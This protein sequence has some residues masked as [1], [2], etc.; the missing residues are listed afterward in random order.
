MKQYET[1]DQ[2]IIIFFVFF[3]FQF[4]SILGLQNPRDIGSRC[5]K[6]PPDCADSCTVHPIQQGEVS[7]TEPPLP[8]PSVNGHFPEKWAYFEA[9]KHFI[10]SVGWVLLE[11][12]AEGIIECVTDNIVDLVR[13]TSDELHSQS[14]YSYLHPGD[15]S[16]LSPVL[17]NMSFALSWDQ[18][19]DDRQ[20]RKRQQKIRIRLLVKPPEGASETMEQKQQRQDKYEDA[21]LIAAP[22]N[23]N[24]DDTSSVLCLI[25]RPEDDTIDVAMPP[26]KLEQ[27]TF[28]VDRS[29]KITSRKKQNT[30]FFNQI[31][32]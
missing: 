16:K 26:Q 10:A 17:N 14:I 6:C 3:Y 12:S 32:Y 31:L 22:I 28:K 9:V 25:T 21:V 15:H 30:Y 29:G 11:I 4:K 8:E 27:L 19:S 20:A 13:Y 23:D 5:T 7:S 1:F 2:L 18:G 24:S